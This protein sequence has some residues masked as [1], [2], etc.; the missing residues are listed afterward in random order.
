MSER[1]LP[2]AVCNSVERKM[3]K[4]TIEIIHQDSDLV[5][6]NKPAGVSVTKDRSGL[7][8]V[9]DRLRGQLG[10]EAELRLIHRLDKYTSGVMII[11]KTPRAQSVYSSLFEKR[12]VKKTYLA[13]VGGIVSRPSGTIKAPLSRNQK[14]V[15]AM[16]V[17]PRSGK[18]AITGWELLAD[19]GLLSLLKVSPLTGR[20]HQ[21]RVHLRSAGMPLAIDP[22]YSG[23]RPVML[24]DFK[25]NYRLSKGRTEKPLIDRMTL[26][27]YQL[28]VPKMDDT[29][30]IT[31][32]AGLDKQFAACIKMLTKH[33]PA[34]EDAF[35]DRDVLSAILNV[36]AI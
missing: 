31:F 16:Y 6:I 28:E 26:H 24:S 29:G 2:I 18:P 8:D 13:L 23:D 11:A 3:A 30:T 9:L 25:S 5:V 22:V 33:S 19:F 17:N 34:A 7:A 12:K 32:I 14:G 27:A 15:Q 36:E 20:T 4:Q 21:I 1:F 35:I 10:S